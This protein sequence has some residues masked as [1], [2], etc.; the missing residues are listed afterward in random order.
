MRN[1]GELLIAR[2]GRAALAAFLFTLTPLIG[3][4]A[5][6]IAAIIV[7]FVTLC[8]GPQSGLFVLLWVALP[9]L[10]LLYLHRVGVTDILLL[11]SILVWIFAVVLRYANSWRVVLEVAALIGLL[12]VLGAHLFVP[13]LKAWWLPHLTQYFSKVSEVVSSW[14]MTVTPIDHLE[15]ERFIKMMSS[16]VT[17]IVAFFILFWSWFMLFLARWWQGVLD[18]SIQ[19]RQEFIGIRNR[20]PV[21]L[22]VLLGVIGLWMKISVVIDL[23]PVLL[24]PLMI[25]GLSFLHFLITVKKGFFHISFICLFGFNIFAVYSGGIVSAHWIC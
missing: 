21:A 5:G 2:T 8:R 12:T 15:M 25:G 4:P 1:I 10:A 19:L 16:M 11:Q 20:I 6:F 3:L 23:F 7:G 24:L 9:A 17:G 22:I 14:R 13:D 18:P